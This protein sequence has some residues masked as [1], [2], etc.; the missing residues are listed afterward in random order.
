MIAVSLSYSVKFRQIINIKCKKTLLSRLL[1][2]EKRKKLF[3]KI[4]KVN[5][6]PEK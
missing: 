4:E 3:V 5:A 6:H 2:F 1:E